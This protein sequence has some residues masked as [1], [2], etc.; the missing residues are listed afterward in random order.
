MYQM[1]CAMHEFMQTWGYAVENPYY[2]VTDE[3]GRFSIDGLPPGT[4]TVTAWRPH[5][6]P[7]ER[8]VTIEPNGTARMDVSFD[9]TTVKRPI[10]ESQERFRIQH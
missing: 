2:A 4:Y 5:F 6:K 7:I 1:I 10:Y 9:A 3:A 8:T